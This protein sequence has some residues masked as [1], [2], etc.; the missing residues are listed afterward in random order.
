MGGIVVAITREFDSLDGLIKC[1]KE[2]VLK[3]YNDCNDLQI[4][5][6]KMDGDIESIVVDYL[7]YVY[8]E[9][10]NVSLFKVNNRYVIQL[11]FTGGWCN[12]GMQHKALVDYGNVILCIID[13]EERDYLCGH[14]FNLMDLDDI[15]S[16]LKTGTVCK[17][18]NFRFVYNLTD[19][20]GDIKYSVYGKDNSCIREYLKNFGA[21]NIKSTRVDNN[22]SRYDVVKDGKS[23]SFIFKRE[24]LSK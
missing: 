5:S 21:K 14:P 15:V 6:D 8:K 18:E 11:L 17:S 24:V 3:L 16:F 10:P 12:V 2:D 19:K 13:T 23:Y 22:T 9:Y 20:N 4:I 7:T 1:V